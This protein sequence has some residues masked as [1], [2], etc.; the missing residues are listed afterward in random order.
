MSFVSKQNTLTTQLSGGISLRQDRLSAISQF[1]N[2]PYSSD[3]PNLWYNAVVSLIGFNNDCQS[4]M[5]PSYDK[6][7]VTATLSNGKVWYSTLSVNNT[8]QNF[9]N[10]TIYPNQNLQSSFQDAINDAS[11]F[12]YEVNNSLYINP[13]YTNIEEKVVLRLG[14]NRKSVGG[15]I[16]LSHISNLE[17]SRKGILLLELSTDSSTGV[18]TDKNIF[19]VLNY[20]WDKYPTLY[21]RTEVINTTVGFHSKKVL[22]TDEEIIQN[23]IDIMNYYYTQGYRVFS[24]LDRSTILQGLLGWF[25][26]YP[27][28]IGISFASSSTTLEIPKSVYRLQ[29][30]DSVIITSLT[31]VLVPSN[32]I[33]Y[34]YSSG[35]VACL[36]V[37]ENLNKLYPNKIV[38]F[39]VLDDSSNLT[40]ENIKFYYK[41]S[42]TND[43][44][45]S[46]LFNNTQND[47]FY[48]LF[49]STYILPT[50]S[51]DISFSGTANFSNSAKEG[52]VNLYNYL[53]YFSFS[54]SELFREGLKEFPTIF[55]DSVPNYLLFYNS[56]TVNG[57]KFSNLNPA[58]NSIL[59]FNENKDLLYWSIL[60]SLYTTNDVGDYV[61]KEERYTL[62]DPLAGYLVIDL[63]NSKKEL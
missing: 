48:N 53:S 28:A 61:Y 47:D 19:K 18:D 29:N 4:V 52:V 34:V 27:D 5:V 49:S 15:C 8:Y 30:P 63:K 54:T 23:N 9:L 37:L 39:P 35:E 55:Q 32:S 57:N 59:Q 40:L 44:T 10:D 7:S 12:G 11:G 6:S 14:T 25:N 51:Y 24:G 17:H 56:I 62:L 22:K 16:S 2:N 46:Y 43:V 38:P 41:E 36:A 3:S 21:P 42:Q 50:S 31:S 45:I 58:H 1:I 20:Y 13:Y 26:Q 60:V 33:Y